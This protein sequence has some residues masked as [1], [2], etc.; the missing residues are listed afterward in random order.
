MHR[1]RQ[2]CV[3][4]IAQYVDAC[5]EELAAGIAREL[6]PRWATGRRGALPPRLVCERHVFGSGPSFCSRRAS[7]S[8]PPCRGSTSR[9]N[10]FIEPRP[11]R[12]P[13]SR[14]AS[15]RT[16]CGSLVDLRSRPC[17]RLWSEAVL[18]RLGYGKKCQPVMVVL[19]N[20]TGTL[21]AI[22]RHKFSPGGATVFVAT[23]RTADLCTGLGAL[24]GTRSAAQVRIVEGHNKA[25][26]LR[27]S[28]V[29]LGHQVGRPR[30]RNLSIVSGIRGTLGDGV[31]HTSPAF[32]DGEHAVQSN[33]FGISVPHVSAS[34]HRV[35]WG[36][37]RAHEV[38]VRT[39]TFRALGRTTP[40]D[41]CGTFDFR[42]SAHCRYGIDAKSRGVLS[43]DCC[44]GGPTRCCSDLEPS[45]TL[46]A[47]TNIDMY[48]ENK[49]ID[50]TQSQQ[51]STDS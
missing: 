39:G 12:L 35:L 31:H 21:S 41:E 6:Q 29:A 20:E 15:P 32:S 4:R 11:S 3:R 24:L 43:I 28:D 7:V 44:A 37:E 19:M 30:N 51:A 42:R 50:P 49:K 10:R 45:G 5:P 33:V 46:S 36:R 47:T 38:A 13:R 9:T 26:L 18:P 22:D 16:I 2:N 8:A 40:G 25:L 14:R 27:Y 1:G 48:H 23:C 34:A 17:T